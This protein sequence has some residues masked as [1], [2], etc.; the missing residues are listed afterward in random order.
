MENKKVLSM[1]PEK[2]NILAGSQMF[3]IAG[4]ARGGQGMVTAFEILAKIFSHSGEFEVQA[5]PSFGVERTGAPIQAFLRISK[6]PIYNRSNIYTPDLIVVFDE[7]LIGQ[8]PV[9][10]G[11]RQDGIILLNTE[12][13]VESFEGKSAVIYTVPATRISLDKGL[14]SKSL[15]IINSA[16]IGALIRILNGDI[17]VAKKIISAEVPVKAAENAAAA[18]IAFNN[19]NKHRS[20]TA[21]APITSHNGIPAKADVPIVPFWH[22]PMSQNKTG[23]WRLFTPAY[24][25]R[26]PPCTNNC[27]AGT[28]VREFVKLTAEKKFEEAYDIIYRHNPF[29]SVCGRVCPHFCQQNC[30]R[31]ALDGELNI[32]AIERFLGDKEAGRKVTSSEIIFSEKVA[33][34]GSGPAGLTVA[35]RL[36]QLG[37]DV[38]VFEAMSKPGGMMRKGIPEFRLPEKALDREIKK[39]KA[40][41]VKIVLNRKVSVN[42]ISENFSAVITAAGTHVGTRLNIDNEDTIFEGIDF[43]DEIKIR[44]NQSLIKKG[45]RVVIIGGGNTAIDVART[46]LR[47]GG[48]P[49]IHYRRTKAEMPAIA[50]EVEEA[51]S[52]GVKI[53]FLSAP[54]R[55]E[56]NKSHLCITMTK[57]ELKGVDGKGRK[58]P[59]P[60]RGSEQE[61]MAEKVIKAT[62][63]TFDDFVFGDLKNIF[64]RQG[65]VGFSNGIPVFCSGDMA[66]GGTVTEAIGSGNAAAREVHAFLRKEKYVPLEKNN[67]VV[68]STEINFA[69]Y[70]PASGNKNSLRKIAKLH[71]DFSEV[72]SGLSN[73]KIVE[74]AK[75]CLHCGDCFSCGNCF[76]YCPD[77]AIS[78]DEEN[79][80][81]IDYEYCK[82]C[83]ICFREC[84]CSA[85]K[86]ETMSETTV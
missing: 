42:E 35:L 25:K 22:K 78:I 63:Q 31:I 10:D 36:R 20:I 6:N 66:W 81:R 21:T 12:K 27:P 41:G 37:Y 61:I 47:L 67:H 77:A 2:N 45:D 3:E 53:E 8:V 72:V 11:L 74:E 59:V 73:A 23:N 62:G 39:I 71:N 51:I 29:P 14:G 19:I 79:R 65:I 64:P 40:Q 48:K 83:G 54:V 44:K 56:K 13:D 75:R 52:E 50:H 70:L 38:T 68:S 16:M 84:P 15:P 86:F 55:I 26:E 85:I 76:N 24:V 4:H 34:I 9:F 7:S 30:N 17:E 28:D 18:E 82:G 57:M 46:V 32:G 60:I 43:L 33:V 80:L 69:H 58:Q 1:A 49:V 5:F